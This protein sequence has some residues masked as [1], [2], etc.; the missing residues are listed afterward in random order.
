MSTVFPDLRNLKN[1]RLGPPP[2]TPLYFVAGKSASKTKC[3]MCEA[4]LP[5][6]RSDRW[7]GDVCI[8]TKSGSRV[9]LVAPTSPY[10]GQ[11]CW[12][13][14]RLD[15]GKEMTVPEDGLVPIPKCG[16]V[17]TKSKTTRAVIAAT[18]MGWKHVKESRNHE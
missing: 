4:G 6:R 7:P 5:R 14:K 15:T 13:V 1:I 2:K 3:N 16:I 12:V 10:R 18:R 8:F 17:D 11:N 9:A